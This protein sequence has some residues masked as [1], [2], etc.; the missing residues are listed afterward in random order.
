M[1]VDPKDP[2][3]LWQPPR[4]ADC[5]HDAQG[6]QI[7]YTSVRSLIG[8]PPIPARA[9]CI[10]SY[11]GQCRMCGH[12]FH[13]YDIMNNMLRCEACKNFTFDRLLREHFR[14]IAVYIYKGDAPTYPL[15]R[16]AEQ[17]EEAPLVVEVGREVPQ[18]VEVV[19]RPVPDPLRQEP[20]QWQHAF[21]GAP[22][23]F[24][25]IPEPNIVPLVQPAGF[26]ALAGN[27]VHNIIQNGLAAEQDADPDADGD[28][29]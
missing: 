17:T 29:D 25:P 12:P 13:F 6:A 11:V 9:V 20:R 5:E 7:I 26:H 15:N 16:S 22:A 14:T 28:D 21:R 1:A 27:G 19:Q 4:D 2:Q 24:R 3:A 18:D 10:I 8:V 23:A